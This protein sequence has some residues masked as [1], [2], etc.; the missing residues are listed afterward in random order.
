MKDVF[1][2]FVDISHTSASAGEQMHTFTDFPASAANDDDEDK[3]DVSLLVFISVTEFSTHQLVERSISCR[4]ELA[5]Y[6]HHRFY[7]H[8]NY[9]KFYVIISKVILI[10]THC[11]GYQPYNYLFLFW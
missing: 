2:C 10:M 6:W 4:S 3:T 11:F 8:I 1:E 5:G 9:Q 7:F